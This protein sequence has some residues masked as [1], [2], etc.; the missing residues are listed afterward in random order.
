MKNRRILK[1]LAAALLALTLSTSLL[2]S[3]AWA[4]DSVPDADPAPAASSEAE[5]IDIET[6]LEDCQ[7]LGEWK[8]SN[9]RVSLIDV[10]TYEE[11]TEG[12]DFTVDRP[13]EEGSSYFSI[14]VHGIGRYTGTK[15]ITIFKDA[16]VEVNE[17]VKKPYSTKKQ[18]FNLGAKCVAKLHYST[19]DS[20]IQVDQKGNV[21]IPAK[22]I[23]EAVVYIS[24]DDDNYNVWGAAVTITVAPPG[25][26][27]TQVKAAKGRKMTVRWKKNTV[28]DGYQVQYSTD[29]SF[30]S[31]VKTETIHKNSVLSQTISGLAKN[32]T[33]YARV[34]TFKRVS[35]TGLY[36]GWFKNYCSAWSKPMGVRVSK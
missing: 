7:V 30:K 35:G 17:T 26:A 19:D 16:P 15:F 20:P 22:F 34:R 31:G 12:K 5:R 33:Y 29:K 18:S 21:T 9:V 36:Q 8:Q 1:R 11:L 4:E 14:V 32:K 3:T 13:Y 24:G 28:C 25:T 2:C 27:L 6:T 23:G 10:D